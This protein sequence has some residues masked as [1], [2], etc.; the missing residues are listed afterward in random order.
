MSNYYCN[1][2]EF[3]LRFSRYVLSRLNPFGKEEN[4]SQMGRNLQTITVNKNSRI[5][6]QNCWEVK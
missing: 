6:Y 2:V 5:E 4:L 1:K 3:D